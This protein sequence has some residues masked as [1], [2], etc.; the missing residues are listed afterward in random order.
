MHHDPL[1]TALV[2][3]AAGCT[4]WADLTGRRR[5]F[6]AF[7]PLTTLLILLIALLKTGTSFPTYRL[8]L[9][10]GLTA[11]LAG[12]VF[13]ML[14]ARFFVAGLASFL[15]AHLLYIG[16]IASTGISVGQVWRYLPFGAYAA[17]LYLYLRPRLTSLRPAVMAY[18][19]VITS[20]AWLGWERA[21]Q[22]PELAAGLAAAGALLFVASDSALAVNRFAR[23]IRAAPLVVLGTYYAAQL[24]LAHSI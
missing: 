16:G 4:I 17:A 20:M 9:V 7:K 14:P 2:I 6:Y 13:L 5:L 23:P 10:L 15:V 18:S 22:T 19:L 21:V 8:A 12:D 24:L 1:L 11:S 3:A